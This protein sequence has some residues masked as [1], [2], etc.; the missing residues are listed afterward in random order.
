LQFLVVLVLICT[1]LLIVFDQKW[2]R[3]IGMVKVTVDGKSVEVPKGAMLI[4]AAKLAGVSLPTLCYLELHGDKSGDN[5]SCRICVVEVAGRKNL[6]PACSTPVMDGMDVKT[7][8]D[9]VVTARK[10]NIELLLSDHA[11][12]CLT[13]A[14]AGKCGL[15][16]LCYQYDIKES[17]Y[18]GLMNSFPLDES[19]E[20][21]VR[22]NNKCVHCRRCVN[23]CTAKQCTDA[24]DF[25]NRGFTSHPATPFEDPVKESTCVSCGNC[26]SVC[27]TAALMPKSKEKFRTWEVAKTTTTCSYCGVGCQM[28]LLVKG[29]KVVGVEPVDGAANNGLLCVKGKFGY[30]F[31]NHPDRLTTP[32]IKKDGK[33]VE[34][35]WDEAYSLIADKITK[36]KAEF[37]GEALAGLTSARVTNEENYLFQ[38]MVRAGFGTNNIDH[39]ARL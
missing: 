18:R 14:K 12:D 16:D 29:G 8:T 30:N 13:C 32:L 11:Q 21:Y 25:A 10:V 20:F 31:V 5:S 4:D 35:S 3:K 19:N 9:R 17:P 22:D 27:P 6:A 24:I 33:L 28:D 38:K 23:A 7:A 34:A 26:V 37:G 36:T 15:Q 2:E 1:G 39:C